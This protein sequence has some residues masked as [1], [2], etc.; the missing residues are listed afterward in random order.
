MTQKRKSAPKKAPS[1]EGMRLNKFL[2]TGGVA[3]RRKADELIQE[4]RVRI[5]GRVV[6]VLGTRID[7]AKDQ[8]FVDEKQVVLLDEPVYIVFNKPKDCITT[9][10]DERGRTTV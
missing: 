8:V 9:S 3:S 7:P 10:S 4:G 2:A 6:T 1:G 5:N